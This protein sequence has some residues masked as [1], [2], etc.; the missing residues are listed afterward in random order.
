MERSSQW[1]N[2]RETREKIGRGEIVSIRNGHLNP[3]GLQ[4]PSGLI[5]CA[6]DDNLNT[7][8]V[9]DELDAIESDIIARCLKF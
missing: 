4:D 5:P 1:K 8:G 3:K 6:F 9:E 7:N 2:A